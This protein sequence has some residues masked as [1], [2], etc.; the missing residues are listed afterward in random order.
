MK[1][2]NKIIL[3]SIIILFSLAGVL[4]PAEAVS[5]T[6]CRDKKP[7]DTPRIIR[8]D[9]KS[10]QAKLYFTSVA[11]NNTY[12]YITYGYKPGD[13]RFGVQFPMKAGSGHSVKFFIHSLAPGTTYAFKVRGGNGCRTGDWSDWK[14]VTTPVNGVHIQKF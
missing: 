12:Y 9:T 5:S 7:S 8:I 14:K 11:D 3:S 10:H 2:S 13:E 6:K 4:S 1:Q